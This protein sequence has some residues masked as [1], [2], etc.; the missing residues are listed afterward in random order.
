VEV[1][2]AFCPRQALNPQSPDVQVRDLSVDAVRG[3]FGSLSADATV[4]VWTVESP[5]E[6]A[7]I[8]LEHKKEL[9]CMTSGQS[10]P[11]TVKSTKQLERE[12]EHARLRS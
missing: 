5:T 3:R 1:E 2:L 8:P 6:E 10:R 11:C 7:T 4:K 9:V 12:E